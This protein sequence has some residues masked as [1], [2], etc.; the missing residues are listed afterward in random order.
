MYGAL[1]NYFDKGDDYGVLCDIIP[2]RFACVYKS[3][4]RLSQ[5]GQSRFVISL[6]ANQAALCE[7]SFWQ[8][9]TVAAAGSEKATVRR[10]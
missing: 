9:Y 2:F 10:K 6:R 7:C 3:E 4:I 1:Y 5:N 8:H